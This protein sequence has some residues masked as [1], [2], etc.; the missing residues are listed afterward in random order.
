MFSMPAATVFVNPA[1]LG[2]MGKVLEARGLQGC[3]YGKS[4]GTA[5]S[6]A[7]VA[8]TDPQQTQLSLSGKLA[9]PL[10]KQS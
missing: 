10:G 4:P 2:V 7:Q 5:L 6:Q 1:V 3:P 8:P 9:A